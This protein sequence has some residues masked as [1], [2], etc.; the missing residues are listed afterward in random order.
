MVFRKEVPVMAALAIA[1][2]G[3][4]ADHGRSFNKER[5]MKPYLL[6]GLF[7]CMA[8]SVLG[9]N[10]AEDAHVTK[11]LVAA[12]VGDLLRKN[13]PK[14]QARMF[15]VFSEMIALERHAKNLGLSDAE[16]KTFLRDPKEKARIRAL[17]S[18][19]L[20]QAGAKP[21]DVDSYCAVARA[22]VAAGT[23]VGSLIKVAP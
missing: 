5:A 14:A 12:Q 19:Y 8:A 9:Q 15:V 11:M 18:D 2:Q 23:V 21:G 6:A 1:Y 17:S 10:L 20:A 13:C 16:I 7:M 3:H 4:W 22:E